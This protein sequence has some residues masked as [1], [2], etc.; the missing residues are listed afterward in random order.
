MITTSVYCQDYNKFKLGLG[1]GFAGGKGNGSKDFGVGGLFTIEP[2][3]RW[4]DNI[5]IGLR[6]ETAVFG[7]DSSGFIHFP[8]IISSITVNGQYYFSSELF[9]P[10]V[11]IGFGIY[12]PAEF[13]TFGFYPRLGFDWGHFTFA[14]EY[15]YASS[16][17]NPYYFGIRV[18]GFFFG[19]KK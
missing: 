15:N 6:F 2:A 8:E 7:K 11:G 5:A 12:F 13:S 1:A 3:Y 4:N 16:S 14:L 17:S 9:R 10:F 19:D 18:G